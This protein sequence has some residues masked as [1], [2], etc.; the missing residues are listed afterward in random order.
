MPLT[1]QEIKSI[2]CP[3]NK[4]QIKK[5]D[6]NGL[7]L[8]I[9]LNGSKLWGLSYKFS[10]IHKEIA[11]GQYPAIPLVEARRLAEEAGYY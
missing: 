9:K 1:A 10:S 5:F 3:E 7:F 11:L 4:K 8:L 6:G 2:C